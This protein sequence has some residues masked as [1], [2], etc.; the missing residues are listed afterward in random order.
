M[1]RA[2]RALLAAAC[3]AALLWIGAV[4]ANEHSDPTFPHAAHQRLFPV[5]EGCHAGLISGNSADAFPDS[6]DCA[7]CHDGARVARVAWTRR[8]PRASNLS[9][10]HVNH[11]ELSGEAGEPAECRSCHA[12]GGVP[13]RMN[14]DAAQPASCMGC[15]EHATDD[16]LAGAAACARCHVPLWSA[17]A[18]PVERVARFPKPAW[19][20]GDDYVSTH[21]ARARD[22]SC[23]VCHARETCERCHANAATV[24][25]IT[26]LGRDARVAALETGRRPTYPLPASHAAANWVAGHATSATANAASCANCHTAPSCVSCHRNGNAVIA[27]L[28]APLPGAASG[29]SVRSSVHAKD[30]AQ[31]H[32]SIAASGR[33][34]CTRC[35][36]AE[37]CASCHASSDS[38]A[39]HAANFVERHA[40]EVFASGSDCQSCHSTETFCRACHA[41]SGV[42]AAGAMKAAFHDG[43]PMWVLTHGQ[44]A[45]AGLEAC[46][47]CHRQNDCMRCHSAAGGWGVNPHGPDYASSRI[48][49][50]STA[51]CRACHLS[52]P[53]RK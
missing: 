21:G 27:T 52:T 47:S 16:H 39:F 50:R 26:A 35:H 46:A 19:H 29:V 36:A 17:P 31:R 1:T 14:V 23:G 5:C 15:H 24:P 8:V 22:V 34:E 20:L 9:F 42:A 11:R 3:A 12:A 43:Q 28:P 38:R 41:R 18:L 33:F 51:S 40:T 53:G 4:R 13:S 37:T 49:A 2:R 6:V 30:I 10:S 7:R 48:A 25:A 44:A 32:G 45:R